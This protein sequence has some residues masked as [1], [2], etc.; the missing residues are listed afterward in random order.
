MKNSRKEKIKVVATDP[1]PG[2]LY[3]LVNR[4]IDKRIKSYHPKARRFGHSFIFDDQKAFLLCIESRKTEEE[5]WLM[6]TFACSDSGEIFTWRLKVLP[7]GYQPKTYE[8]A[9]GARAWLVEVEVDYES[10]RSFC[11]Q[12]SHW[13]S[14]LCAS[15]SPTPLRQ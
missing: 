12:P 2:K 6:P 4:H 14:L 7:A 1:V 15:P 9:G 11:K 10:T 5:N 13:L 3:R 8:D